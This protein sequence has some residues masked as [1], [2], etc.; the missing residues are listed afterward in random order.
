VLARGGARIDAFRIDALSCAGAAASIFG[1]ARGRTGVLRFRIDV[2]DRGLR[3]GRGRYRIR[4][5]DG[6][7]SGAAALRTGFIDIDR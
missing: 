6:F 2:Q 7:D 3:T 1:Q 4:S 5:T